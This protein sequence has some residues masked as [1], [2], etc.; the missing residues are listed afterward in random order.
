MTENIIQT[1]RDAYD[2]L[3]K[4]E[5]KKAIEIYNQNI[6]RGNSSFD[7]I[8]ALGVAYYNDN[9]FD[10]AHVVFAELL[11]VSP[12]NTTIRTNI[13]HTINKLM[14]QSDIPV[15]MKFVELKRALSYDPTNCEVLYHLSVLYFN[16]KKII[17]AYTTIKIAVFLN[18]DNMFYH[19]ML[20]K[21]CC[22]LQKWNEALCEFNYVIQKDSN[23]KEAQE[24]IHYVNKCVKSQ[25]TPMV[26]I[27]ILMHVYGSM[28]EVCPRLYIGSMAAA[29]NLEEL[30]KYNI[31]YILNVASEVDCYYEKSDKIK[32]VYH[33]ERIIDSNA[34]DITENGVL[35]E[36][37]KFIEA[38]IKIGNVLVHCQAGMSRSGII[39]IAFLMKSQKLSY[40]DAFRK[41]KS[42]RGC[43]YP[44]QGFTDQ[45]KKY[46]ESTNNTDNVL[47]MNV[48]NSL[49]TN[50]NIK[51]ISK[52]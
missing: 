32:I 8:N 1:N 35:D 7:D 4:G 15:V 6:M 34:Y 14:M 33:H 18:K 47:D 24:G 44:N 29:K 9:E 42:V 10:K 2:F 27:G 13:A 43:V 48:L 20:G 39:V 5:S 37:L 46:F 51:K 41:V 52:L 3:V 28:Q 25:S 36:C 30:K 38:S 40:D 49:Y 45:I 31:S 23:N 17:K 16:K 21:I 11:R 22:S 50:D 12:D 26:S 19:L